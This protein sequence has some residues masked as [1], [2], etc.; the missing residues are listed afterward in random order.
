MLPRHPNLIWAQLAED[1]LAASFIADGHHLPD[2][3]LCAMLRAKSLA[4]SM[5]VSDLTALGGMPPGRYRSPIGGE[6]D[7][8]ADGR[9]GIPG[10]PYLAGAARTLADGVAHAI[11]AARLTLA[12]AL[13][14]ATVNPGRALGG[15]GELRVGARA[16]L[17]RFRWAPGDRSLAM[18]TVLVAGECV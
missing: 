10:T 15:G 6:V 11:V 12:E 18:E 13:S 7:L 4:R 14:L 3:T 16:D 5:L 17:I 1:R 8:S 2:D 9:L